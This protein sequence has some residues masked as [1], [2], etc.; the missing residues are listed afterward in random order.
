MFPQLGLHHQRRLDTMTAPTARDSYTLLEEFTLR[1]NNYRNKALMWPLLNGDNF[2]LQLALAPAIRSSRT[3]Q[4][5]CIPDAVMQSL[6]RDTAWYFV[7]PLQH[8][9]G[10]NSQVWVAS[11]TATEVDE[12]GGS[13][14][15]KIMQ[16]SLTNYPTTDWWESVELWDHR[17]NE[18]LVRSATAAYNRLE[19]LQGRTLPYFLGLHSVSVSSPWRSSPL[20]IFLEAI[21]PSGEQVDILAFEHLSGPSF[22]DVTEHIELPKYNKWKDMSEYCKIV[23]YDCL[24]FAWVLT[25]YGA[26]ELGRSNDEH[27]SRPSHCAWRFEALE[28]DPRR[29]TRTLGSH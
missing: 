18:E 27:R 4:H 21:L 7:R 6:D 12:A 13:I 2:R 9:Q 29:D 16:E 22:A 24:L 14:V 17:F 8:G 10:V 26:D 28:H 23:R 20:L 3:E 11:T 19:D 15:L 5:R 1:M 25:V